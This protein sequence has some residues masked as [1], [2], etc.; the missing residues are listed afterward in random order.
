MWL[1][2][3]MRRRDVPMEPTAMTDLAAAIYAARV[4]LLFVPRPDETQ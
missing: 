4:G 1:A 3:W 2:R